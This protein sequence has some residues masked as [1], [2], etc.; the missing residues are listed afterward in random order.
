MRGANGPGFGR[1]DDKLRDTRCFRI[2]DGLPAD[3]RY[4]TVLFGKKL[5]LRN[6]DCDNKPIVTE[7]RRNTVI[8]I[9]AEHSTPRDRHTI[10]LGLN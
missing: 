3:R 10:I 1:R 2:L 9:F 4:R 8:A 6:Q 7:L 5:S